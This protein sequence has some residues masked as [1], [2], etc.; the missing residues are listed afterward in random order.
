MGDR[1][2]WRLHDDFIRDLHVRLFN[3]FARFGFDDHEWFSDPDLDVMINTGEQEIAALQAA[4]SEA[5]S[6]VQT[7]EAGAD[8]VAP[9]MRTTV[10]AKRDAL[11]AAQKEL[12]PYL[13]EREKRRKSVPR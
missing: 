12:Q 5:E 7:R 10:A 1:R 13:D 4:F 8:K 6:S 2:A 11:V 9:P 3:S